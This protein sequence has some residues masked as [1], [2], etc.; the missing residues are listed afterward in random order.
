LLIRYDEN[1]ID[2]IDTGAN[3]EAKISTETMQ[4]SGAWRG[5]LCKITHSADME[6]RKLQSYYI[7]KGWKNMIK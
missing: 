1:N 3:S 7:Q 6:N 2:L 5:A 4:K